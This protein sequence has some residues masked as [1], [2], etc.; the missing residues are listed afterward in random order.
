MFFLHVEHQLIFL[1]ERNVASLT[2]QVIV[3]VCAPQFSPLLLLQDGGR[4]LP[5]ETGWKT[6]F[7]VPRLLPDGWA[8]IIVLEA[9]GF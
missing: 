5:E 8:E 2:A 6:T 1:M 9:E 4:D 7:W 3:P